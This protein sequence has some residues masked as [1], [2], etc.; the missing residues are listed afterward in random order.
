MLRTNKGLMK[1]YPKTYK[2][3]MLIQVTTHSIKNLG[4]VNYLTGSFV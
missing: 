3:S 4:H 2:Q 1:N